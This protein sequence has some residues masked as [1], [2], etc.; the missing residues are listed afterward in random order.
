[1][2]CNLNQFGPAWWRHQA[3]FS[4]LEVFLA[5]ALSSMLLSLALPPLQTVLA[6]SRIEADLQ[7]LESALRIAQ[8]AAMF[9]GH[10]VQIAGLHM[11][12]NQTRNGVRRP[13]NKQPNPWVQ[14]VL[15][16]A[17]PPG[18]AAD[19]YDKREDLRDY[20]FLMQ[21]QVSSVQAAY[22]V[23]ASAHDLRHGTPQFVV[24]ERLSRRCASIRWVRG[25]SWP[26]VCR[27]A[28]CAGCPR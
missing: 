10:P 3:G 5:L 16:Y 12:C 2:P 27:G 28:H 17:N 24:V 6:S 14:G 25:H 9:S 19:G 26:E 15:L 21:G 4:L 23:T 22:Q 8:S 18:L 13:S 1:M 11:R 7:S 20:S